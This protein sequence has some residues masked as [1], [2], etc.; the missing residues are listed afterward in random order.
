MFSD[1]WI[2][3]FAL[4]QLAAT[5]LAASLNKLGRRRGV[6]VFKIF[7]FIVL[8]KSDLKVTPLLFKSTIKSQESAHS[9]Y[10]AP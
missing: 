10:G 5:L 4:W 1:I 9:K 8:W 6:T 3:M 7:I 2:V